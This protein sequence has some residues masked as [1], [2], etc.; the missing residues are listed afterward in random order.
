VSLRRVPR[1]RVPQPQHH[2]NL[3]VE[4]PFSPRNRPII[5]PPVC[6]DAEFAPGAYCWI[7]NLPKEWLHCLLAADK[8]R[9]PRASRVVSLAAS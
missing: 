3:G 4:F 5:V 8:V 6:A 9:Y 7:G 1:R 2:L